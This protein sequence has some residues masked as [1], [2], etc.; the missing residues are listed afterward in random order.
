MLRLKSSFLRFLLDWAITYIPNFSSS[1]LV[2]FVNFLDFQP[3]RVVASLV[4]FSCTKAL[5]L[6]LLINYYS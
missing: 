3:N 1:N 5:L 6:L 2:D 4:Y